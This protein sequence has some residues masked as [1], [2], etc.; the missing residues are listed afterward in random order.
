MQMITIVINDLR[1]YNLIMKHLYMCY[2][3][4]ISCL[5]V[6][7]KPKSKEAGG[8]PGGTPL[9]PPAPPMISGVPPRITQ[10]L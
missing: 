6:H 10:L 4:F 5:Y 1:C 8:E 3:F 9:V 7:H 2:V